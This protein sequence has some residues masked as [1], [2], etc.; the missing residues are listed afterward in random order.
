[1]NKPTYIHVL[2]KYGYLYVMVAWVWL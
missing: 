2:M 1:M